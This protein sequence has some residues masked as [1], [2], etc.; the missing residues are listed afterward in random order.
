M[1]LEEAAEKLREGIRSRSLI[2]LTGLMEVFYEGR[3]SSSLGEGERLLLIKQDGSVLVHR[4][5]GYEPVNWQPPGSLI[6]VIVR[7]GVLVIEARRLSPE[8]ILRVVVKKVYSIESHKLEDS[9]EFA[10]HATEEEMKRAI[11]L[12]PSLIEEG[13]KPI[14]DERRAGRA[15]F[16]DIFGVDSSG[17][18]VVV[19]I[20]RRNATSEDVRQLVSYVKEIEKELGR[21]PRMILAAPGVQRSASRELAAYGVEFK[22]LSPRRCHEILKRGRGLEEFLG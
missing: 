9:A 21:R 18:L 8:E 6:S 1:R 5:T 3:A 22:C 14:E 2:V 7:D 17:N 16:V 4:P 15:G 19:E 10:M 11:L 13:F 12:E 20:K